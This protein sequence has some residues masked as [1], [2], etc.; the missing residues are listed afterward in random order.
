MKQI[1]IANLN[2]GMI[3][4]EKILSGSNQVIVPK[5]TVF[6]ENII[7]R[8][9]SYYIY[10][11]NVEEYRAIDLLYPFIHPPYSA[12]RPSDAHRHVLGAFQHCCEHYRSILTGLIYRN[13]SFCFEDLLEEVLSISKSDNN[14]Q[15]ILFCISN[16]ENSVYDHCLSVALLTNALS[17]WLHFSEDDCLTAA[18]C[19]LFHDV[20]KLLL[21][22]G[23]FKNPG[24]PTPE[25]FS[26]IKTHT[27]E[28]FHLLSKLKSI[29]EPVR[30]AALMH[31]ERHDAS[32][33]PYGLDGDEISKFA[34]AVMVA[35]D[36]DA[37]LRSQAGCTAV[38]PI[39]IVKYF[40]KE[41]LLKYGQS[42]LL[43]FLEHV[44]N[45]CLNHKVTLSSGMGGT[46][47]FISHE[48]PAS[49]AARTESDT[50]AD[51]QKEH[52]DSILRLS[53]MEKLSIETII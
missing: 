29:P 21:P 31:H 43:S 53:N 35:D 33:Y 34:K 42:Y 2:P 27:I 24:H 37:M 32:G 18:A 48:A 15:D 26:I 6:T 12:S 16:T 45:A 1:S 9:E 50:G 10:Y 51:P 28:G 49:P 7:T 38:C 30:N 52:Y 25:E 39:S 17:K 4:A 20:G 22:A 13:E 46:V 23:V 47:L 3:A 8:L 44:F 11:V 19:G 40:E 36:F 5:G 14:V 41:G